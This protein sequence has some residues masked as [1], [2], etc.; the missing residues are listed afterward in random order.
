MMRRRLSLEVFASL[1]FVILV[2]CAFLPTD[3]TQRPEWAFFTFIPVGV[4]LLLIL[5]R[6]WWWAAIGLGVLAAAWVE[7][8]QTVWMPA[9]Y[10]EGVDVAASI[11][12]CAIGVAATLALVRPTWPR[13]S[14]AVA[15]PV[16]R[17][18][19]EMLDSNN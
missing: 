18:D 13:K 19:R 16:R 7:A 5:G 1:Y 17:G 6:R 2:A 4:F 3:L 15:E 14:A 11:I 12:G 8:A 10:A 9:G